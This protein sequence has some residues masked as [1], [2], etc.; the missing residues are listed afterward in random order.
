[1]AR[2]RDYQLGIVID[3]D[4]GDEQARVVV[5]RVT[6]IIGANG[7]HVIRVLAW[8]RRRLAYPI[9]HHR[10]GLYFWY[11]MQLPGEAVAEVERQLHVNESI[12]RHLITS[13]DPRI[14]AVERQKAEEAETRAHLA[15]EQ[16]EQQAEVAQE[17]EDAHMGEAET[18]EQAP[19]AHAAEEAERETEVPAETSAA[20]DEA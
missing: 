2:E 1:M 7:G 9:E 17:A 16:A 14:V 4:V 15:Q 6:G 8:G 19:M 13:R 20:T 3:P 11:D 12:I 10:D 5:E 18:V